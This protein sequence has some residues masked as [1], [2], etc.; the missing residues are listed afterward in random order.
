MTEAEKKKKL[1]TKALRVLREYTNAALNDSWKGCGDP[2]LI[3]AIGWV[4]AREKE[5][6]IQIVM[7]GLDNE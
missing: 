3:P 6:M 2:D 5:K 4:Y 7:K 1:R